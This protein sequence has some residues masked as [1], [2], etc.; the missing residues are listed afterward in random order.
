M[1]PKKGGGKKKEDEDDGKLTRIAI[2]STEK[3][4]EKKRAT[5]AAT[6]E[7]IVR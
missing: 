3:T 7:P 5:S 2:I 4:I 6:V 1:G